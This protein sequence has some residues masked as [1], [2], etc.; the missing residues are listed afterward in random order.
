[1]KNRLL[2]II[3]LALVGGACTLPDV[4]KFNPPTLLDGP[5]YV[6][7]PVASTSNGVA[8]GKTGF[9]GITIGTSYLAYGSSTDFS[10]DVVDCPGKVSDVTSSISVPD[11][12]TVT[13][14]ATSLAALKGQTT[15]ETKVTVVAEADPDGLGL[16]RSCNLVFNVSDS[17]KDTEANG[18]PK[19]ASTTWPTVLVRCAWDGLPVGDY[20]VTAASGNLDGGTAYD[21]STIEADNGGPIYVTIAMTR[22]GLYTMDE[23]TGGIWPIYYSG[24]ANPL[25]S[26][27][28]CP[29]QLYGHT[30]SVTTGAGTTSTRVFTLNATVNNDGTITMTWS[31]IRTQGTPTNPAQG[32]YTLTKI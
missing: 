9:N 30:G 28:G 20:Q 7:T 4:K 29:T 15:G 23:V 10:I 21:L 17:Q 25:L 31:Y 11:Y 6:I 5:A 26:V 24:R 16:D 8:N 12:G 19:T 18:N 22:P 27:D 3:T 32:T 13:V 14:D 2:Q 1:M